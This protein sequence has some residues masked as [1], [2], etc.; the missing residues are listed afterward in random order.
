MKRWTLWMALALLAGVL[1]TSAMAQ[2]KAEFAGM[3]LGDLNE[4]MQ[5][6]IAEEAGKPIGLMVEDVEEGS[7]ADETGILPGDILIS[8]QEPHEDQFYPFP[9]NEMEAVKEWADGT[10]PTTEMKV[11]LLRETPEEWIVVE[12]QLGTLMPDPNPQDSMAADPGGVMPARSTTDY[13]FAVG[14]QDTVL[15]TAQDGSPLTQ[16]DVDLFGGLIAWAFG[17]RL[18]EAQKQTIQENV[19][20]YWG[21]ATPQ[22]VQMFNEGVRVA[23]ELIPQ[24]D[25]NQLEQYR[26]GLA[27]VLIQLMQQGPDTPLGQVIAQVATSQE[28]VLAG[29]GTDWPLTL[30]DV[31]AMLEFYCFQLEQMTGMPVTVTQ[32]EYIQFAEQ[33]VAEY[34]AAGPE[35]Q[36]QMSQWDVTWGQLR[37]AWIQASQ[38]MQQQQIDQWA[39]MYMNQN[40]D[41]YLGQYLPGQDMYGGGGDPNAYWG[42][43]GYGDMS[44]GYDATS[45]SIMSDMM[46]TQHQTSMG[47]INNMGGGAGYDVYDSAG[48][49]LYD[50]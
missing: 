38:E 26:Q 21:Y 35:T 27:Q 42:A 20:L 4:E 28:Q 39:Q 45:M 3:T 40:P 17:T 13:S 9:S 6:A 19:T 22:D 15:A 44:G 37:A 31:D 18:T 23:P 48:N 14:D 16:W 7:L 10:V 49:W 25:E 29:A 11:L 41:G 24:L 46:N 8:V 5:A 30:Q 33:V 43:G 50:Y 2:V 12:G 36:A 32:E 34:Q 1:A 47:I